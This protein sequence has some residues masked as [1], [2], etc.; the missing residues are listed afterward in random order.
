MNV[1]MLW[2]SDGVDYEP[3]EYMVGL[4]VTR[5]AAERAIP[6]ARRAALKS[7]SY[8]AE[9]MTLTVTKHRVRGAA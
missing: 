2:F 1:F 3:T 8:A 5:E 4:Y 9:R 7:H 6:S